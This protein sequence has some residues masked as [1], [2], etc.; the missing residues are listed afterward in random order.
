[1]SLFSLSSTVLLRLGDP[2][3]FRRKC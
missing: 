1:M 3:G 2:A